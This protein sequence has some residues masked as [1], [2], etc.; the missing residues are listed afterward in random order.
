MGR[1]KTQITK[2]LVFHFG[3][4]F[5]SILV[6]IPLKAQNACDYIDGHSYATDKVNSL[7]GQ[8]KYESRLLLGAGFVSQV[9]KIPRG[10]SQTSAIIL[11]RMEIG[12][13]KEWHRNKMSPSVTAFGMLVSMVLDNDLVEDITIY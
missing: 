10:T 9:G 7:F 2:T 13:L 8:L 4:L 5:S 11:E 1:Y 3:I 6:V 12:H